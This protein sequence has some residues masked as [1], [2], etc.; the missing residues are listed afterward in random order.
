MK[1]VFGRVFPDNVRAE[2]GLPIDAIF[3]AKSVDDRI[4]TSPDLI[5]TTTTLLMVGAKRIASAYRGGSKA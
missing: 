1:T 2:S 5:G 3:G 4:V